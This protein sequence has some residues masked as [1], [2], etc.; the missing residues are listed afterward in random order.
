MKLDRIMAIPRSLIK[1]IQWFGL[2]DGC[3]IPVL[4]SNKTRLKGVTRGK[5]KVLKPSFACVNIGF[6]G[7]EGVIENRYSSVILG[8]EAQ[9]VFK[10]RAALA[11]G[12]SIRADAGVMTV[13]ADFSCNRNCFFACYQGIT[14]GD[15]VLLGWNVNIRDSDGHRVF[16]NDIPK[17]NCGEVVIGNHVWIAA[18]THVLKKARIPDECVVGY[19]SCVTKPFEEPH[20]LIAG[21]PAKVICENITWER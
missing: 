5:I 13:G 12:F 9:L 21:Y 8:K 1:N 19:R 11:S 4:V 7:S 14:I 10:G 6:G 18:E 20:C 17:P 3:K 16:E 15:R 2:K